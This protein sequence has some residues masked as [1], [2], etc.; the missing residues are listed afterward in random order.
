MLQVCSR[1][2]GFKRLTLLDPVPERNFARRGW[3]TYDRRVRIKEICWSL[4]NS[5]VN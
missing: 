1:I 2:D 3:V 4:N 5:K